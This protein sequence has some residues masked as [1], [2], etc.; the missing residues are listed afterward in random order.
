MKPQKSH[1]QRPYSKSMSSLLSSQVSRIYPDA[2][3]IIVHHYNDI[4]NVGIQVE[5]E[6]QYNDRILFGRSVI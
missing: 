2:M 5:Y 4:P 3:Y 6:V 1:G